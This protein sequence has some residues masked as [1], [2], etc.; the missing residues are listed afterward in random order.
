MAVVNMTKQAPPVSSTQ[1]EQFER[2][3]GI[4]LPEAY[5][6]F[7]LRTNG[8]EPSSP[9]LI[10]P[11]WHGRSTGLS[12]F[13]G[14]GEGG[15]YDLEKSLSGAE[16]YVPSGFVPI[17]EDSGG[18][19]LCLGIS[20]HHAGKVFFWDHEVEQGDDPRNLHEVAG[21]I[22]ELLEKLLPPDL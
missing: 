15:N 11:G 18:N 10:V 14:L 17:A 13:F 8:G 3:N 6:A 21:S 2:R 5:K 4:T 7:L 9:H 19:M 1:I 16:D 12:R 22:E 20:G